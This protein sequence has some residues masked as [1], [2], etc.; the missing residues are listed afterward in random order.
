MN[1][2]QHTTH[3]ERDHV[4]LSSFCFNLHLVCCR[5]VVLNTSVLAAR[6]GRSFLFG[7]NWNHITELAFMIQYIHLLLNCVIN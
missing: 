5:V 4:S 1:T 2:Q 6:V 7:T 3:M